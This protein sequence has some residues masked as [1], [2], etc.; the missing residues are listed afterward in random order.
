[1]SS[2]LAFQRII[3]IEIVNEIVHILVFILH[4]RNR[5]C[6]TLIVHVNVDLPHLRCLVTACGG[7]PPGRAVR[8]GASR[9]LE[10]L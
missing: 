9:V 2:V 6:F 1:M 10:L 3:N 4:L 8:S 5:M 7:R